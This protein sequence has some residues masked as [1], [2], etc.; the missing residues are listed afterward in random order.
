MK[1]SQVNVIERER[2]IVL[3]RED[4]KEE[5]FFSYLYTRF[6]FPKNPTHT[7]TFHVPTYL[8]ERSE[9]FCVE[10]EEKTGKK[11]TTSDLAR[12]LYLDF[13]E[14]VKNNNDLHQIYKKLQA[15]SLSPATIR[16]YQTEEVYSG[17]LSEEVR[18]FH[19][20]ETKL[21][22]RVA[23]RG[24][25][26]LCDMLEIYKNHTFT[27]ENI[28]EIV[29]CDFIDDYRKGLIKNPIDKIAQYI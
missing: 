29:F 24:E 25:Q 14:Y 8:H 5:G 23:L 15:R 7:F 22:H 4:A 27:L 1:F 26:L 16:P 9:T 17:V 6:L 3:C 12:A 10:V 13:I 19:K 11:F 21:K 20:V 18:G 2:T 28:L